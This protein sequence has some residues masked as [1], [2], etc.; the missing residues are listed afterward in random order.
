MDFDQN[1]YEIYTWKNWM[2][3][4][5]IINPGLAFNE[6]ILG[7]RV[8][9]LSLVEKLPKKPRFERT[10]V[11]CPHCNTL[12][13]GRTWSE[14][15]N[16]DFKNWFGLY[17]TQCGG[18]IPCLMNV[19]SLVILVLTFPIWG[20]FRKSLKIQWLKNQPNRFANFDPN[21]FSSSFV[22]KKW[23]LEGFNYG[24]L[25]FLITC[26]ISPYIK[27]EPILYNKL[28]LDFVIWMFGGF[29]FGY[30]MMKFDNSKFSKS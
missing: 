5:W 17:C 4:H 26:I 27:G 19:F 2:N 10:K 28:F 30:T 29:V 14:E 24:L 6:L 12:H 8:P 22:K 16:T 20:W 3:L 11:P 25:M 13:D 18:I 15:N 21:N 1:K 7:Q 23:K 9:K